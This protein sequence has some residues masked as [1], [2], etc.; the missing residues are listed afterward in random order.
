MSPKFPQSACPYILSDQLGEEDFE[1]TGPTRRLVLQLPDSVWHKKA[2]GF[3]KT[4]ACR[5]SKCV[6]EVNA[7]VT[8]KGSKLFIS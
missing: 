2:T 7:E 3:A 4:F 6:K 8:G 1:V 5:C